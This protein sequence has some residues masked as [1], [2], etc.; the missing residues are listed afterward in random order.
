M[1]KVSLL[2]LD[3]SF[4]KTIKDYKKIHLNP[5]EDTYYTISIDEKNVGVIGFK[6][7]EWGEPGLK[8]GIHQDYRGQGI[9]KSA[10]EVLVKNYKITKIFSEVAVANKASVKAH[11]KI[12]FKRVGIKKENL[13]KEQG[14]VYKRNILLVKKFK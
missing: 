1:S 9:F 12:G 5:K 13:L 8:I 2:P 10:L 14:F 6:T 4:V 3:Y 7:E 11:L